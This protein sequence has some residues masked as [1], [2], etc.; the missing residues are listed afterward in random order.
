MRSRSRVVGEAVKLEG[1]DH[2]ARPE[3]VETISLTKHEGAGN[4]FLIL[5]DP[6]DLVTL[7]DGQVRRLC[8]RHTGVGADGLIKAGPNRGAGSFSMELRNAD[9][10][11]AEMS[12]NGIRCLAQALETAGLAPS[13][14][15]VV[16]TGSGLRKVRYFPGVNRFWGSASVEMGPALLRGD[17]STPS[18]AE[19][20]VVVEVGNPHLVV[21]VNDPLA[22]DV[23][24]R[25]KEVA[26][27][28][29][30]GINVE[31]VAPGASPDEVLFRVWE[32]GVGET[33]ACGTGSIAAA[34]AMRSWGLVGDA[35]KVNNPGGT[36]EVVLDGSDEPGTWLSGP[37][38]EV[39]LIEVEMA[40]LE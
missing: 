37:V 1:V 23:A 4:D 3:R 38:R 20:A 36:L 31:F 10:T 2:R 13:G 15:F 11:T 26:Q 12:G 17:F 25:A 28:F 19:R 34:A 5:L 29:K 22:I 39:A 18:Y 16:E 33:L 32:R 24:A 8:E 30:D 21:L 9:G 40:T 35:V 7:S 27:Q 6:D 14:S